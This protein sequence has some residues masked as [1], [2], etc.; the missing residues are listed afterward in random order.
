MAKTVIQTLC[1]QINEA[2]R[3]KYPQ[4]G[5]LM[6]SDIK[7]DGQNRKRVYAVLNDGGGVVAV[8]NGSYRQTAKNLREVLTKQNI[9]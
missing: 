4:K 9:F 6:F 1:D 8:H 7:G 2:R 5:Y 3:V